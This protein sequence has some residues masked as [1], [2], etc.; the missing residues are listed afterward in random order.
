MQF[1]FYDKTILLIL[2][3]LIIVCSLNLE[4]KTVKEQ[5]LWATTVLSAPTAEPGTSKCWLEVNK[6]GMFGADIV[7]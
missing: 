1:K 5:Q 3:Y 7:A 6:N 2:A 4:Y